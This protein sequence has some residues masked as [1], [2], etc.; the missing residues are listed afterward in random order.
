MIIIVS[1]NRNSVHIRAWRWQ[2][3]TIGL[4]NKS[5]NA[6]VPYPT[7][8]HSEQKCAHFC[9]QWNLVGYGTGVFWDLWNWSIKMAL[10]PF[11]PRWPTWTVWQV[12]VHD[13]KVTC[14]HRPSSRQVNEQLPLSGSL[15]S[16]QLVYWYILGGGCITTLHPIRS[17]TW[18]E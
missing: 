14:Q 18:R 10:A 2:Q 4:I 9:S 13:S 8:L 15:H 3:D 1:W 6:P 11:K 12:P 16:H 5:Q 17:V 7:M